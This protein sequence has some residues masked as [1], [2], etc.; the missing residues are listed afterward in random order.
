MEKRI[1]IELKPFLQMLVKPT[2]TTQPDFQTLSQIS[3]LLDVDIR[4]L[5]VSSK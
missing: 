1:L 2:K 3:K 4:E 5:L